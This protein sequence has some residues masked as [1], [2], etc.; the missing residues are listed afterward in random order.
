MKRT[1]LVNAAK[2]ADIQNI[3]TKTEAA[4]TR[5]NILYS[6]ELN[7]EKN[8]LKKLSPL[9]AELLQIPLFSLAG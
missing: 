8:G 2:G 6:F 5:T 3:E 7:S 4:K 1:Q 9:E